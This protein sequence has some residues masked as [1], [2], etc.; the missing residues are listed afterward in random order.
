LNFYVEM[1]KEHCVK[2]DC[3]KQFTSQNYGISTNPKEEWLFVVEDQEPKDPRAKD[4][5]R[6]RIT[7]AHL[8]HLIEHGSSTYDLQ[9]CEVIAVILYT[10]P[11]VKSCSL[12]NSKRK[13]HCALTFFFAVSSLQHYFA[14]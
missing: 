6:K 4:H 8:D 9:R 13:G 3:T 2:A 7:P 11:M 12:L 14:D 1:Q 5:G 10:G